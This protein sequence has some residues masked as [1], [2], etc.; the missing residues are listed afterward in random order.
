MKIGLRLMRLSMRY[1]KGAKDVI[2]CPHGEDATIYGDNGTGKTTLKDAV[3]WLFFDKD[4]NNRPFPAPVYICN[5][6]HI[7]SFYR[8]SLP[9]NFSSAADIRSTKA[10]TAMRADFERHLALCRGRLISTVS[11]PSICLRPKNWTADL[12][13]RG[14]GASVPIRSPSFAA[15]SIGIKNG[16]GQPQEHHAGG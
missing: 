13:R 10:V 12:A 2:F 9:C 4:S 11:T 7:T 15:G 14:L 5:N 6:S 3:S 1:F 8:V 16:A